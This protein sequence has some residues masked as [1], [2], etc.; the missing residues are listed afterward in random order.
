MTTFSSL[1]HWKRLPRATGTVN[2]DIEKGRPTPSRQK[3]VAVGAPR[4]SLTARR[5]H[6]RRRER[7]P[8][9]GRAARPF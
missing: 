3:S 9:G 5:D 6:P 2:F 4:F 7:L 8:L 1:S